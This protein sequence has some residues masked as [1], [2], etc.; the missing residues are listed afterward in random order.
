MSHQQFFIQVNTSCSVQHQW[1]DIISDEEREI[2]SRGGYGKRKDLGSRPV[3]IVI[4][5]QYN[6]FG[7]NTPTLAQMEEYPTGVGE[8][9]WLSL[10]KS[11]SLIRNARESGI[12]VIYTRYVAQVSGKSHESKMRRDHTK[13][14]PEAPG[15]QSIKELSHEPG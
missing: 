8:K 12:P 5:A 7:R 14:S 11:E 1:D 2:I 13:F 9:S 10:K 4:D 6:F 15:S 3:L